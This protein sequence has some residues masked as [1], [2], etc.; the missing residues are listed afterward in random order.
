MRVTVPSSP[1]LPFSLPFSTQLP[2]PFCDR[3]LSLLRRR[4]AGSL[5][6]TTPLTPL[7][8]LRC[9]RPWFSFLT[10]GTLGDRAPDCLEHPLVIV[11]RRQSDL[12]AP[13]PLSEPAP[14]HRTPPQIHLFEGNRVQP[15]RSLECQLD[16]RSPSLGPGSSC[17]LQP[18]QS[19]PRR[20]PADL[21]IFTT[22]SAA[23]MASDLT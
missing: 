11:I 14:F 1:C 8:P 17:S 13:G 5:F 6:S 15:C 20:T 10:P 23:C 21:S 12:G 7:P 2:F 22:A 19:T 16:L 3:V 18:P 4:P 9:G